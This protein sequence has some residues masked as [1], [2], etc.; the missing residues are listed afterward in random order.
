[1][2]KYLSEKVKI[3][4]ISIDTTSTSAATQSFS[5]AGYDRASVLITI[6]DYGRENLAGGGP[7][8]AA[9]VVGKSTEGTSSFAALTG[10]TAVFASATAGDIT[11][12][13]SVEFSLWSSAYTTAHDITINGVRFNSTSTLASSSAKQWTVN[14]IATAVAQSLSTLLATHLG[15]NIHSTYSGSGTAAT[16]TLTAKDGATYI[17]VDS[18]GNSTAGGGGVADSIN[19]R[20]LNQRAFIE[21]KA[22]DIASTNSSYTHFAVSLTSSGANAST[23][24]KTITVIRYGGGRTPVNYGST[25][26]PV[27]V[28]QTT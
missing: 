25:G 10:A 5:M 9:V 21:F 27:K 1:M 8:T 2:S 14:T 18:T 22:E 11:M 26:A 20:P 17:T 12:A 23:V 3:D 13:Q 6:G 15:A 19:I 16:V 28:G 24:P 4:T 7:W